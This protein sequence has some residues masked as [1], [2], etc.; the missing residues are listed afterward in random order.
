MSWI[1]QGQVQ[2][3]AWGGITSGTGLDLG[4]TCWEAALERRIREK[5][6]WTP[7]CPWTSSA[8][9]CPSGS[10][11]SWGALG[12]ALPANQGRWSSRG[13]FSPQ[14][15]CDSVKNPAPEFCRNQ[16]LSVSVAPGACTS[17]NWRD[18]ELFS[19]RYS[20]PLNVSSDFAHVLRRK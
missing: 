2:G 1:Q 10:V 7:C 17:S 18:K 16:L 14:L 12:R 20:P 3:S 11:V 19:V 15:L 8:P 13:P 5:T 4:L 9:L 6:W